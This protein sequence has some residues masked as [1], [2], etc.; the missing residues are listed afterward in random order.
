[1]TEQPAAIDELDAIYQR[2]VDAEQAP[3]QAADSE[4]LPPRPDPALAAILSSLV[5]SIGGIV[6]DRAGVDPLT[7]GE[8]AAVGEAGA[9]VLSQY[10]LADMSPRAAAWVGLGLSVVAVALPRLEQYRKTVDA[11]P[12][13]PE[14][15]EPAPPPKGGRVP[16]RKPVS[17]A[18]D[19]PA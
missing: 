2:Y 8:A 11:H 16:K 4:P 10:D 17:G 6:T 3:E 9:N 19:A 13:P 14:A 5:T 15:D 12:A 1:M 7:A 18:S